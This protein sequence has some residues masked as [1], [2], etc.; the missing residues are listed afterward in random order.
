[1]KAAIGGSP[2]LN[3]SSAVEIFLVLK[4]CPIWGYDKAATP[5]RGVF[6][7]VGGSNVPAADFGFYAG[8][9]PKIQVPFW[10]SL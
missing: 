9:F 6:S 4:G 8:G 5:G 7:P 1:M 10:K 3:S 2:Y